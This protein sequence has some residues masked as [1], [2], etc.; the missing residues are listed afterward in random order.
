MAKSIDFND[1]WGSDLE[2]HLRQ[3]TGG[4]LPGKWGLLQDL[5]GHWAIPAT[6]RD[7]VRFGKA[8]LDSLGS[9]LGFVESQREFVDG[10]KNPTRLWLHENGYV[11]AF[12]EAQAR[13]LASFV[14]STL[15]DQ[16]FTEKR[17][18]TPLGQP[19][20][21]A[22]REFAFAPGESAFFLDPAPGGRSTGRDPL[23]FGPYCRES[24]REAFT[25]YMRERVWTQLGTRTLLFQAGEPHPLAED[26]VRLCALDDS[27]EFISA[28]DAFNDVVALARRCQAFTRQGRSRTLL[29]HGPPGTGKSTLARAIARELEL[30][31][32]LVSCEAVSRMCDATVLR[33]LN[34]LQPGV[35]VL[36][37][38]DRSAAGQGH[39]ALLQG[40]EQVSSG[41]VLVILTV[42]DT[43]QLDPAILRPGRVH[44][45]LEVPEP[46]RASRGVILDHYI[47]L[48]AVPFSPAERET[49]LSKSDGFSPADVREFAETAAAVGVPL[50]IDELER[51]E[52]QRALY[53]GDRCQAFNEARRPAVGRYRNARVS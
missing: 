34:L 31:L 9:V 14:R 16:E 47:A 3:L 40:L 39:M 2:D 43:T 48:L 24:Q 50:A 5:V 21:A 10:G 45:A 20:D 8:A 11:E 6:E 15:V 33:I 22:L 44:E 13:G 52:R 35:I 46:S 37:D 36:N 25:A 29:L 38:V 17:I 7:W 28:H 23:W 42:N 53:A 1:R 12:P 26:R 30:R 27:F 51:I 18:R 19:D 41:P 32:V 49:F 4:K